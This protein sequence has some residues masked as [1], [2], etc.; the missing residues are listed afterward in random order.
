VRVGGVIPVFAFIVVPPVAAMLMRK[1][2][3]GIVPLSLAISTA[4]SFLGLYFSVRYDFPAGPSIV[5]M[6]GVL[7][8]VASAVRLIRN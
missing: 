8:L 6:L 4:G 3:T 1:G 7:F 5:A 2:S